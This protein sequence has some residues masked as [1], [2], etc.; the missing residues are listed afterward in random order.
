MTT[1]DGAISD[2]AISDRGTPGPPGIVELVGIAG[3]ARWLELRL[4]E[5]LGA[6]AVSEPMAEAKTLFG[7]RCGHHAWHAELWLARIP[8]LPGVDPAA[9]TLPSG[10][11][12]EQAGR[13]LAGTSTTAERLTAAYRHALPALATDAAALLERI[14]ERLDGPST[15]TLR[16]VLADLIDD[17]A[18][19][20]RLLASLDDR[21]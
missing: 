19:G 17:I 16:L 15:R 10:D 13:R 12:Y 9:V 7:S 18:A 1:G 2:G 20:E 6:W 4:F 14:D 5:A 11:G 21:G 3:G 8:T